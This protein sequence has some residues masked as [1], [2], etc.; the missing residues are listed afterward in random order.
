MDIYINLNL[1]IM[2]INW[3]Q[4]RDTHKIKSKSSIQP[5]INETKLSGGSR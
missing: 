4:T 1:K 3:M 5:Y 2:I